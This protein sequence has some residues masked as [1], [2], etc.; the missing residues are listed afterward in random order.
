MIEFIVVL[1]VIA[2]LAVVAASRL[3]N[4]GGDVV[5]TADTLVQ[6]IARIRSKAMAT[7]NSW[8]FQYG[9]VWQVTR[10][11]VVVALP[12]PDWERPSSVSV[13]AGSIT[14][15]RWG[16]P[17]A[18]TTTIAVSDGKGNART[19]RIWGETGLVE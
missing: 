14:F 17:T 13:E 1:L 8:A 18:G 9:A 2:F 5:A 3:S 12:D 15:T 10:D 6:T 16:A 11:G 7:T 4:T 19:V